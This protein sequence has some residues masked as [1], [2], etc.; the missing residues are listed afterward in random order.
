MLRPLNKGARNDRISDKDGDNK[1]SLKTFDVIIIGAGA[2]G[3]MCAI[4]AGKRER[5]VLVLEAAERIGKKIL[6]SGGGRC[7]FTNIH[8]APDNYISSNPDFCRSA[9]ARYKPENFLALV[10]RHRIEYFEKKLG[11][12]FCKNSAREIVQMLEAEC[13]STNVQILLNCKTS[14]L[15]REDDKF[16]VETGAGNFT[17]NSLVIASGGLSIPKIGATDFG[18]KVATQFGLNIIPC[19]AALVPLV[20]NEADLKTFG[21]LSGISF[22]AI[23]TCNKKSFAEKILFTHRGLSGPAI[24]QISSYWTHGD[25]ISINMFPEVDLQSVFAEQKTCNPKRELKTVLSELVSL[26]LA[27]RLCE[28]LC[29]SRAIGTIA[30]A[31]LRQFAQRLHLFPFQPAGSEGF[32]KAEVTAG[33][34][35]TKELSSQT[36]EAKKISGLYFIGEVLDVTGQL[37]G[38]NFQWAWASGHAAGQAA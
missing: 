10:E 15:R 14:T 38:F 5:R 9:L 33:G 22:S 27:E 11:Q 26:R 23:A 34:I 17:A 2:A 6:I 4:E 13:V 25:I 19:R 24:L 28:V 18:Y 7:N 3:L 29:P 21:D 31:E 20:W 16:L 12:L 36:F 8:A 30:D 1:T 37:G 32:S 35:D